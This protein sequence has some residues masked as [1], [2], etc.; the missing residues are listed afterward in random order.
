MNDNQF[1][2]IVKSYNKLIFTVCYQFVKDYQEAENL[3]QETFLTA[4]KAI[5]NFVGDHY[6]AWLVK[7][8]TNKCKD[9]LKSA[10]V[11]TTNVVE[12][13]HLQAIEDKKTTQNIVEENERITFMKH[14]CENL[15]E[16]YSEVA[17]KYFIEEKT[18]AE[19]ADELNTPIKTVQTRA[20]RARDKLKVILKEVI[21]D[22][23]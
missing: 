15:G 8:A 9:F 23:G 17:V 7:I 19:I 3:T 4:Y 6:K 11:R 18:F 16:P 14:A 21:C 2:Q 20:Y 12:D 10:Y 1:T 5:D 13:E 22:A